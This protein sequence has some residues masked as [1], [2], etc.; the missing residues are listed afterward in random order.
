V[1]LTH[2]IVCLEDGAFGETITAKGD[3]QIHIPDNMSFEEAATLGVGISTVGQG[4][5]QS[6]KLPLPN[7]SKG[8]RKSAGTPVLIYGGSTLLEV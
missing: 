3:I 5:Y 7:D 8:I 2:E 4:L 1:L 6:M